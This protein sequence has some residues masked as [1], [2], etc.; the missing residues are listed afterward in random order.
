[1][2]ESEKAAFASGFDCGVRGP[3][4]ENCH[5]AIFSSEANRLAWEMGKVQGEKRKLMWHVAFLKNR[6]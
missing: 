2:S 3:N 4:T 6:V 1:M 5:F